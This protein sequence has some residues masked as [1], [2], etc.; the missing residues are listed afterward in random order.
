[1]L[2]DASSTVCN[3]DQLGWLGV[4][5]AEVSIKFCFTPACDALRYILTVNLFSMSLSGALVLVLLE[6]HAW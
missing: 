3:W 2:K 1:M 4:D 5:F 6:E